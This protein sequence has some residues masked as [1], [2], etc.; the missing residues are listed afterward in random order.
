MFKSKIHI[1]IL[2]ASVFACAMVFAQQEQLTITTYYPSPY[3]V[4]N[5]L[6]LFPNQ[7]PPG[8][9]ASSVGA[10]YYDNTNQTFVFCGA[11]G[12]NVV[13]GG[14]AGNQWNVSGS[15]IYYQKGNV[16]IGGVPNTGAST[17]YKLDV[18]G[19]ARLGVTDLA[20]TSVAHE[21]GQLNFLGQGNDTYFYIDNNNGNMRVITQNATSTGESARFQVFNAGGARIDRQGTGSVL[22]M[23]RQDDST[24]TWSLGLVTDSGGNS[25]LVGT[26]AANDPNRTPA[27]SHWLEAKAVIPSNIPSNPIG[28]ILNGTATPSSRI[29]EIN[30]PGKVTFS[31]GMVSDPS[32]AP[33]MIR[34]VIFGSTDT[35]LPVTYIGQKISATDYYCVACT[36]SSG[37]HGT[38]VRQPTQVDSGIWYVKGTSGAK[39]DVA[40]FRVGVTVFD[41]DKRDW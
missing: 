6:R 39:V 1:L 35:D 5:V 23:S 13:I 38:Y 24:A 7:N 21:G 41:G 30:F 26:L 27:I 8:C 32:Q 36:S 37:N 9:S 14:N 3:G 34:R 11:N 25:T 40:C 22:E 12:T 28:S 33:I 16:G 10:M 31:G 29:A 2:I 15:D 19:T 18:N 17:N 4:Y 20:N